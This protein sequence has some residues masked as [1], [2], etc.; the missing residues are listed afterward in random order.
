MREHSG[1]APVAPLV[2]FNT[3]GRTLPDGTAAAAPLWLAAQRLAQVQPAAVRTALGVAAPADE[4]ALA[5]ALFRHVIAGRSGVAFAT[6]PSAWALIEHPEQHVRLAIPQLLDALG[7]LD[8]HELL[9]DPTYPFVLS[10]GQRRAQNA[11][12]NFRD[13]RFR[14]SD[15]DGSLSIHP[16]DLAS[17]DLAD[18]D[19][20]AVESARGRL[21]VRARGEAGLRRGYLTLPHGYGQSYHSATANARVIC[22]PRINVLTDSRYRDP[23]A[24]TPYHK[25]VPVRIM[26]PSAEEALIASTQ[27][28][29]VHADLASA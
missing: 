15:P 22:G 11:N 3:L 19:W 14:R 13:P 21:V 10:A 1:L 8:G 9:P 2:L 24:G 27:S 29:S 23:I 4:R 6:Q 26:R 28:A 17:L 5:E 16:A 7:Q 18:G 12:Q 20:V 25:A